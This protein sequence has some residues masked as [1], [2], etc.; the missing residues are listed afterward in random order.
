MAESAAPKDEN[1]LYD[2][3]LMKRIWSGYLRRTGR[4]RHSSTLTGYFDNF[5]RQNCTYEFSITK[6]FDGTSQMMV[7]RGMYFR[8]KEEVE[9]KIPSVTLPDI[10][11]LD[12][13]SPNNVVQQQKA[14][15][16]KDQF[17]AFMRQLDADNENIRTR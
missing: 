2:F 3:N 14:F 7:D 15:A 13:S 9:K 8:M 5:A 6:I 10:N 4:S 12:M 1:P 17:H 11:P 16:S